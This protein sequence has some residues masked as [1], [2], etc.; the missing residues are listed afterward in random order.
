MMINYKFYSDPKDVYPT[1][2]TKYQIVDDQNAKLKKVIDNLNKV[3]DSLYQVNVTDQDSRV[4]NSGEISI[5]KAGYDRLFATKEFNQSSPLNYPLGLL[6]FYK[7][8]DVRMVDN[9]ITT[10]AADKSLKL[11]GAGNFD[12]INTLRIIPGKGA[13]LKTGLEIPSG[14]VINWTKWRP[15]KD[16]Q[17]A[18]FFYDAVN[19]KYIPF[20]ATVKGISEATTANWDDLTFIGRADRLYSYGGFNRTLTFNFDI[21]I[22]SVIEL[23]PT[24]KRINY[25][26][27]LVKPAGYTKSKST[28][29]NDQSLSY[30]KFMIPPMVMLTIGDMYKSQPIMIQNITIGIPDDATWETMNEDNTTEWQYLADYIKSTGVN[31]EFGQFPREAKINVSC[32]LLE[33]ERAIMGAANFGHAPH[34]DAY[35]ERDIN[36]QPAMHKAL[37]EYQ[38]G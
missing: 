21:V 3:S 33:K 29:I 37:V 1:K 31:K 10:N 26:M 20:R 14:R 17:I 24:W 7:D 16:D 15:Y 19:D 11:P 35:F 9:S 4:I 6:K 13:S 25:L 38:N 30:N 36:T 18:F 22:S 2:Q 34:T 23:A 12:A 28:G 8:K 5:V 32:V 27:S